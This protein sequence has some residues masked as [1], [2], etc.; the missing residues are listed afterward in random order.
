MLTTVPFWI[1]AAGL[2]LQDVVDI[3]Q[4]SLTSHRIALQQQHSPKFPQ[5]QHVAVA[6]EIVQLT[7]LRV[8]CRRWMA[9]P[10]QVLASIYAKDAA[11]KRYQL[12]IPGGKKTALSMCLQLMEPNKA[13]EDGEAMPHIE[14]A[15]SVPQPHVSILR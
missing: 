4:T 14:K 1:A 8:S 3:W 2:A 9:L 6:V 10:P 15:G 7:C 12:K 13:Q 11:R 5:G